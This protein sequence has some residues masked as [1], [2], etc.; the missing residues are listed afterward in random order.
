MWPAPEWPTMRRIRSLTGIHDMRQ[1]QFW[2]G[3]LC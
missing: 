3:T 1:Q 2:R